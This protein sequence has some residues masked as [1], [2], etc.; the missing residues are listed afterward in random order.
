MSSWGCGLY[1]ILFFY[2]KKTIRGALEI[3]KSTYIS[4][5]YI[6]F[7]RIFVSVRTHARISSH[8][9]FGPFQ[10]VAYQFALTADDLLRA[11]VTASRCP[12]SLS[13]AANSR[14]PGSRLRFC[15]GIPNTR[16]RRPSCPVSAVA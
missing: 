16:P 7:S 9:L 15:N 3:G 12:V 14:A 2:K 5:S 4:F 13:V 1:K 10:G 6:L 11:P 8:S